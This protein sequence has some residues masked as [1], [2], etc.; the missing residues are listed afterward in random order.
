MKKLLSKAR[1]KK[2]SSRRVTHASGTDPVKGLR[3][4]F[5]D[6]LKEMLW[7]EKVLVRA[8]SKMIQNARSPELI[9]S[10]SDHLDLTIRHV[11]R[12][13]NA[14]EIISCKAIARKCEAVDILIQNMEEIIRHTGAGVVRDAG[15]VS[16]AQK[17][18]AYETA[19]YETLCAFAE[20]LGEKEAAR[21]LN[22]TLNEE[23]EAKETLA[24]VAKSSMDPE[25]TYE[26]MEYMEYVY[27]KRRT[28]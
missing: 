24:S 27:G 14:F 17:I 25:I 22:E 13:E 15:I 8:F 12:L 1:H 4:L 11:S 26:Y 5:E 16:S 20:A 6:E 7:T 9:N 18:A 21:L 10:M 19:A 23:K 28:A 3:D 2:D